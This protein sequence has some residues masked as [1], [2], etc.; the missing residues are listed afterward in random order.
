M[1]ISLRVLYS[2]MQRKEK[3]FAEILMQQELGQVD[4]ERLP[5]NQRQ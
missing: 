3:N 4:F 2:P 1:Y 5:R